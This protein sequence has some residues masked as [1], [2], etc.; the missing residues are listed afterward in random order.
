MRTSSREERSLRN[1][2]AGLLEG[3]SLQILTFPQIRAPDVHVGDTQVL[4]AC[5]SD[6]N[7]GSRDDGKEEGVAGNIRHH[8]WLTLGSRDGQG[9][10]MEHT[11]YG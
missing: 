11:E 1:Q 9:V 2:E 4:K 8:L 7:S 3:S 6:T 10:P 5:L